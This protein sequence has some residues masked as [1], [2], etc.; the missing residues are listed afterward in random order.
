MPSSVVNDLVSFIYKELTHPGVYVLYHTESNKVYV[1]STGNLGNRLSQHRNSLRRGTHENRHLQAAFDSSPHITFSTLPTVDREVAY[2]K[3]QATI[4]F[5]AGCGV[6]LNIG[7]QDV[8][9]PCKGVKR[10]VETRQRNREARLGT[11]LSDVTKQKLS[12]ALM[13]IPKP[14]GFSEKLR[15]ANLNHPRRAE[16]SAALSDTRWSGD[17]PNAKGVSVNGVAYGSGSEAARALGLARSVFSRRL[18]SP[19]HPE[20]VRL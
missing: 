7:V 8:R 10:S 19:D 9:N 3:E 2:I 16:L 4:D 20:Y 1:G 13:G 15:E 17:N 14:I 11:T 12:H 6:L 18:D 5:L